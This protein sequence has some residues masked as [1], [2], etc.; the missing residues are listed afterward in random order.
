MKRILIIEDNLLVLNLTRKVLMAENFDVETAGSKAEA[1][2]KLTE[3]EYDLVLSDLQLQEDYATDIISFIRQELKKDTPILVMSAYNS[4]EMV[5]PVLK[6]GANDF[7]SKPLSMAQLVIRAKKLM[8]EELTMNLDKKSANVINKRRVAIIVPCYNEANRLSKSAFN[9]FVIKNSSYVLCFVN[10]GSKDETWEVLQSFQK[11]NPEYIEIINNE[12]NQGKSETV[13]TGMMHMVQKNFDII[14]FLDADLSTDFDEV[15]KMISTMEDLD[16]KAL[17]GSRINRVGATIARENSRQFISAGINKLIQR[18]IKMPF[19][20]TQCGAKLFDAEIVE[21]IFNKKFIS[22]WLF[23]VEIFIRM[24]N[25]LGKDKAE[26][27]IYEYPLGKWVHMD[28]SKLGFKDSINIFG[29]L[30]RIRN[31]YKVP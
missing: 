25:L 23:D 26:E 14:G 9:E 11:M 16:H 10:D 3:N 27:S 8:G 24:K 5:I 15:E 7:V 1:I 18:I 31:N 13:R 4:D 17:V 28:D 12:V 20:D 29:E 30:Y 19:R 22:R 6:M 2:E 21:P